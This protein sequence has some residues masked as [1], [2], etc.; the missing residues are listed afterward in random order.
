MMQ[1]FRL[2]WATWIDCLKTKTKKNK[3][4]GE[5]SDIYVRCHRFIN[6]ITTCISKNLTAWEIYIYFDILC[7]KGNGAVIKLRES[8]DPGQRKR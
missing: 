4:M 5:N 2:A 3:T 8:N 6:I 7:Y 1:D